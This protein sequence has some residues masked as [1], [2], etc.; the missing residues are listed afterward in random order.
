[1]TR[2]DVPE[3]SCGHCTTA[4]EKSIKAIDPTAR[5]S[6]DLGRKSVEVDSFLSERAVSAA[7]RDAGYDV[8]APTASS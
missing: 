1:M 4:I 2:F 5:V 7:I 6:C 8:K 3:M